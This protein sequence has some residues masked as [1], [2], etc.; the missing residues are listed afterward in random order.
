MSIL[1]GQSKKC[2]KPVLTGQLETA[3]S[4]QT[5]F[6]IFG[7]KKPLKLHAQAENSFETACVN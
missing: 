5:L 4:Q 1:W 3:I 7:E 2:V 6:R